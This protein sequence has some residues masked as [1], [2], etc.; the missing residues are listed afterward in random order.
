MTANYGTEDQYLLLSTDK[1]SACDIVVDELK[2]GNSV[3]RA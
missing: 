2:V 1:Y 3:S